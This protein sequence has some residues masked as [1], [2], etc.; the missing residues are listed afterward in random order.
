VGQSG[1]TLGFFSG[2]VYTAG[3]E[4]TANPNFKAS[5]RFDYRNGSEGDNLV[6]TAAAA[7]KISPALTAL[8]RFEQANGANIFVP[9]FTNSLGGIEELGN[10]INLRVGLAYRDP[11]NDKFNGLLRYEYRQNPS[12]IPTD[13]LREIGRGGTEHVFA[14]EG[15][16]APNWRW[17]FYGKFAMRN[18][19]SYLSNDF[20][21]GST[22]YLSQLRTTYKLGYRTDLAVEGR[23][24]GQPGDGFNEFGF[25]VESG[26]YVTPDLRLGLGYSFGSVDDRDFTGYRSE[27]GIYVN[28]SLKLNELFGGFGRQNPVPRQ[29]QESQ[30]QPVAQVEQG[31]S[32]SVAPTKAVERWSSLLKRLKLT[33]VLK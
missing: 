6:I 12:T 33:Q 13:L 15:I 9:S 7:G 30:V 29:E 32:A 10:T 1:Y 28:L 18:S 4:Y 26:Y 2:D 17:E 20:S 11:N 27:G 31:G 3:I 5:A 8:A 22:V 16:Y 19:T 23:W 24:I 14:A 21:N 25:A